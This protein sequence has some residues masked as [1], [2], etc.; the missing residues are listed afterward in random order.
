MDADMVHDRRQFLIGASA[1][2]GTALCTG[3]SGGPSAFSQARPGNTPASRVPAQVVEPG[4]VRPAL[5]AAALAA[6][7]RHG[8]HL[9]RD[10]MAIVDFAAHSSEPR[11]HIVNIASGATTSFLVSHGRGSD[12]DNSGW[13]ERF[14]NQTGSNASSSGAFATGE[15][16][17]GKHGRSQRLTGLD[18]SNSEAFA[19]AIVLHGAWYAEPGIIAGQGKIGRS[20]GCF[21]VGDSLLPDVFGGLGAGRLI[22]ADKLSA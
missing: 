11:F 22:Y 3:R 1:L 16:Y 10:R 17:V 6:L 14:S 18:P 8:D 9:V 12:P 21:A 4:A 13:L 7:E 2:V 20:Q 5:F 19:R 15:Y